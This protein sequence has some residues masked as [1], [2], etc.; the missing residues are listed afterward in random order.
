MKKKIVLAGLTSLCP[1]CSTAAF[2]ACAP[3]APEAQEGTLYQ[4]GVETFWVGIGKA[5]MTFDYIE[6]P[7]TPEEDTLYGYVFNVNVDSGDGYSSWLGGS[8]E[9]AE[10]ESTL[11]LT[12]TWQEGDKSTYLADATSGQAKIYT[13]EN[14][15][16]SIGVNLPSAGTI[17]F[18]LNLEEDKVGEGETPEP[19]PEPEPG[20]GPEEPECTEHVDADGDG[21][22]DNC[23][24]TM[25]AE[26]PE[27][28]VAMLTMTATGTAGQVTANAKLELFSQSQL[29]GTWKLS[30]DFGNGSYVE[31]ASGTY[32][33][34]MTT[35]NLD[36]TVVEG[37]QYIN[38]TTT[39]T[40]ATNGGTNY[41]CTVVS[42]AAGNITL[43][44]SGTLA[45]S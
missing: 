33:L 15:E 27:E 32:A 45:Q 11:T 5:Y 8:W 6:E 7:E 25:P 26:T 30:I 19:K 12:A 17:N 28:P 14:G 20:P 43:N 24:E 1:A 2:A 4:T 34:N 31:Q 9:L 36:L 38:N 35:Y 3:D 21:K 44:F 37:A 10:D 16:F 42:T 13:A 18:T 22:C 29:N 39:I 41:T 40:V 23:G